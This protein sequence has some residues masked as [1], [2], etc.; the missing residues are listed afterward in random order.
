MQ[1]RSALWQKICA[2]GDFG[3]NVQ[4]VIGG[5]AYT[6]ISAPVIERALCDSALSVGNCVA[7]S[8]RFSVLTEDAIP[9]ASEV[10]IRAQAVRGEDVGEWKEFGTFFIDR[11]EEQKGLVTLQCFDAM[12]KSSQQYAAYCKLK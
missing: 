1:E 5:K 6:A 8:L 11:R 9:P 10:K 7:A 3:L 12:L 2:R 4:A